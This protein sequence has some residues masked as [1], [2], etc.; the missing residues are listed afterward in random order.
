MRLGKFKLEELENVLVVL[1]PT[2]TA[3]ERQAILDKMIEGYTPR[4]DDDDLD[5]NRVG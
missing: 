4:H 5:I 1:F 2:K 3:E